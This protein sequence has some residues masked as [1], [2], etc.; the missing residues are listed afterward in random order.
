MGLKKSGIKSIIITLIVF[1]VIY[2][3]FFTSKIY[4]KDPLEPATKIG[5]NLSYM[6]GNRNVTLVDATYDKKQKLLEIQLD[7]DNNSTDNIDDYYY[8]PN[9]RV[10]NSNKLTVRE[11]YNKPMYTVIRVSNLKSSFREMKLFIA[12]RVNSIDKI[13]DDEFI[14]LTLN[15]NNIKF[16]PITN[17][18]ENDYLKERHTM[19]ISDQKEKIS[20]LEKEVSKMKDRLNSFDK[21]EKEFNANKDY[22]TDEE[23]ASYKDRINSNNDEKEQLKQDIED[24]NNKIGKEKEKLMQLY[25]IKS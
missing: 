4:I 2:M 7:L 22:L 25:D 12:P 5:S 3:I 17:R 19:L 14:E 21:V 20:K 9:I 18:S 15:K 10:G 8:V 13:G 11:I 16:A 6:M 24:K 23:K 1:A